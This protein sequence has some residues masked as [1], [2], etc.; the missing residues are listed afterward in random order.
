LRIIE[1]VKRLGLYLLIFVLL[2]IVLIEMYLLGYL[3]FINLKSISSPTATNPKS[4]P[5]SVLRQTLSVVSETD[6]VSLS[7]KD[8][9]L[10]MRH[11][12]NSGFWNRTNFF[13]G[14]LKNS[15]IDQTSLVVVLTDKL[16]QKDRYQTTYQNADG[17]V[18]QGEGVG[19]RDGKT[20][21][22]LYLSPDILQSNNTESLN[23]RVNVMM[24]RA[25]YSLAQVNNQNSDSNDQKTIIKDV[26]AEYLSSNNQIIEIHK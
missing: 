9:A 15:I 24:L 25:I 14:A 2:G 10:L 26:I 6:L 4:Y 23:K 3:K 8:Q 1:V 22:I 17:S 19:V 18:Y 21:L 13:D 7:L 5:A 20:G 12:D 11:L 16:N